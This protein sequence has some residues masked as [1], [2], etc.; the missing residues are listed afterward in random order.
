MTKKV[1][2]VR[3]SDNKYLHRD[4]HISADIG[5]AYVGERFGDNGV[6]EYLTDFAKAYYAPLITSVRERGLVAIKE[7]LQETY[8]KE[9]MA[10]VL[11]MELTDQ[12]LLVTVDR[13]PAITY[14]K[15]EG[16]QASKWYVELTRTV[17][18]TIADACD[19]GFDLISYDQATGAARYRFFKRS[20]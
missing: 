8:E 4:F 2:D 15:Q 11:H 19:L 3:A 20:F 9:E 10:E 17:H 16:H 18:E 14:F 5:V 12:E 13:C 1:I 6:R 7:H